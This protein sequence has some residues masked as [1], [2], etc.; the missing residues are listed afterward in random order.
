VKRDAELVL[1]VPTEVLFGEGRREAVKTGGHWR[2]GGK[3]VARS[4]CAQCDFEGLSALFHKGSSPFQHGEGGMPFIQVAHFGLDP[5]RIEQAPPS[6][7]EYQLLI[8]T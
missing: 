2:V 4:R 7:P 8:K 3:E 6:D 5:E 1:G